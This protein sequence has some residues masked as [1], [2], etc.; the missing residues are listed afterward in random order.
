MN[1]GWPNISWP[2]KN[3]ALPIKPITKFGQLLQVARCRS[4]RRDTQ[5]HASCIDSGGALLGA[6]GP[7]NRYD[8]ARGLLGRECVVRGS[9]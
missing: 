8:I 2:V 4:G 1:T 3:C 6:H 7:G 9:K 5:K